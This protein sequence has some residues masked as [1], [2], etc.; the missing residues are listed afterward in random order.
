MAAAPF[1]QRTK[2]RWIVKELFP[3]GLVST[4]TKDPD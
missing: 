2:D 1:F 4:S 3:E